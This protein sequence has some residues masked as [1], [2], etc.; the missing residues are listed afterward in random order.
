M[1]SK[2]DKHKKTETTEDQTVITG[3]DTH[4]GPAS[5]ESPA[6]KDKKKKHDDSEELSRQW[7]AKYDEV[8][9]KYLRM[10]SEFDNYR[11]RTLKEKVE[12][13]KTA[14]EEIIVALLPV[15][16]DLER[17]L[18]TGFKTEDGKEVVMME[19][20]TLIYQKFKGLLV[21]RGLEPVPSVGEAFDVD[22]HDALTNI[23]APSDDLKGKVIDEIEKGYKLNGKVIRYSKVV[24]GN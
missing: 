15:I 7:Q 20:L 11:K 18:A 12:L 9:D 14:S 2:E 24:V 21:Q 17:A 1:T 8:N 19:G 3:N 22:F 10:Y 5:E 16:D 6:K 4:T 23:P 13:S